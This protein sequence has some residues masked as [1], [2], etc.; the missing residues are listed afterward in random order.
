MDIFTVVTNDIDT[1]INLDFL[2]IFSE[3]NKD[4][5]S[6]KISLRIL[7]DDTLIKKNVKYIHLEIKK[8]RK[9]RI[10]HKMLLC[11]FLSI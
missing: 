4:L 3:L 11:I 8:N 5:Y 1:L 2:L 10:F 6:Q 9:S 7:K